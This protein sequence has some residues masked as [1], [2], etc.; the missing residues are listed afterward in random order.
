MFSIRRGEYADCKAP[1]TMNPQAEEKPSSPRPPAQTQLD[2]ER[3]AGEGMV[4]PEVEEETET[5]KKK[6]SE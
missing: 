2:Q 5:P 3:A 1:I 4:Q 6:K